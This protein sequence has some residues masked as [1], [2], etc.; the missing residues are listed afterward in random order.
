[1]VSLRIVGGALAFFA[2]ISGLMAH[3]GAH[4]SARDVDSTR[5]MKRAWSLCAKSFVRDLQEASLARRESTLNA[6]RMKRSLSVGKRDSTS[7]L[8]TDHNET[9][10]HPGYTPSTADELIFGNDSSVCVLAAEQITGPY[11]VNGELIRNHIAENQEGVDLYLDIQVIDINTCQGIPNMFVDI[12]HANS[13]GV[14]SGVIASGNGNYDDKSNINKTFGRG[15]YSTDLDGVVQFQTIFPGHYTGR[16]NHIHVATHERAHTLPN[17]TVAGGSV[18]H[19]GQMY[20][21]QDL[22]YAVEELYPYTA[23]TQNLTTNADDFILVAAAD[24]SDADPIFDY[25]NLGDEI[26]DGIFAWTVLAVNQSAEY[27]A[28]PASTWTSTGGVS[29]S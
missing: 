24:D 14:Y 28:S 10:T 3:P 25:V 20:F 18:S 6:I 22:I 13:T 21:D 29:D 9:A 17:N 23:N 7:V 16:T 5:A 1:M 19:I 11:Y 27:E 15:I 8:A 4:E 12:W 2:T 26:K